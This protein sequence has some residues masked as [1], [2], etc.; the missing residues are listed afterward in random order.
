MAESVEATLKADVRDIVETGAINPSIG[1]CPVAQTARGRLRIFRD[2]V[3]DNY[4]H[5]LS[6]TIG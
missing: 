4:F 3:P 5:A 1:T 6:V 2:H